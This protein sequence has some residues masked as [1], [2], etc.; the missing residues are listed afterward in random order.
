MA[1]VTRW[2]ERWDD[3]GLVTKNTGGSGVWAGRW[4]YGIHVGPGAPQIYPAFFGLPAGPGTPPPYAGGSLVLDTG[5][6]STSG[7]AI[8]VVEAN[9]LC[10][11][12]I[13]EDTDM[14]LSVDVLS[15]SGLFGSSCEGAFGLLASAGDPVLI[16]TST[17]FAA[18]APIGIAIV[19]RLTD[20][21]WQLYTCL[22]AGSPTYTDLG[23]TTG[24]RVRLE[25]QGA[26]ASDDGSPRVI[27][28][29]DGA[30]V[31]N[32]GV[33]LT[34]PNPVDRMLYYPFFW[35]LSTGNTGRGRYG[36]VDF[37]AARGAGDL[38]Y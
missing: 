15:L 11:T 13:T 6:V 8:A 12:W 20:T 2:Q 3:V 5:N 18:T 16:G 36:V 24:S 35:Q 37:A 9:P 1:K 7:Q 33:D 30:P 38:A 25:Y 23:I 28:Y 14:A 32:F 34:P 22:S 29:V 27:V 31:K 19:A 4:K 10:G 26:N 17:T 21:H